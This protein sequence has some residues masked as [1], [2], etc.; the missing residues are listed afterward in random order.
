MQL[1]AA[2]CYRALAARDGRF[3]GRFF[4]GVRTTGI[5]CRPV[6]PARTPLLRNVAFYPSAAAAAEAGFRPCRRCRPETAPGTPAWEGTSAT[7]T[8]ALRLVADGALDER[9]VDTLA[10][11]LGI[12]ERHLRRLFRR[13]LGASPVALAQTRRLHFAKRLIDETDLPMTEVALASGYRSLRRF[14]AAVRDAYEMAPTALRRAARGRRGRRAWSEGSDRGHLSLRLA[15]REPIALPP[16]FD[17]LARRAVPGVEHVTVD[18][19]RRVLEIDDT[20]VCIAVI[21]EGTPGAI[22]LRV[23][24][25]AAAS[26]GRIVAAVRG[27]FDLDADP[28]TIADALGRDALLAPILAREPGLRVPGA[29]DGHEIAVR[30]VLGQ[31]VSVAGART[32]TARL[33]ARFGRRQHDA[34]TDAHDGADPLCRAFPGPAALA[35]A[36]VA[37]IG[38]PARRAE[39]V[40]T[41]SRAVADGA[42]PLSPGTDPET[43]REALLAIPGIGPWTAEYI[44]MRALRE[45]DAFPGGDLV[46]RR[47]AA[48]GAAAIPERA[49]VAR[50]EAW[51]PWRAYAVVAL[52]RAAATA[53]RARCSA[54]HAEVTGARRIGARAGAS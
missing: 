35:E 17:F 3:D 28:Q 7:V 43:T 8:R 39:A 15:Y 10:Q 19:Y 52:W 45:P 25:A 44:A 13:H 54:A 18:T 46:L 4:V 11:R 16:L 42:L 5:Y 47:M 1:D 26:L 37:A 31:Q 36:D 53:P 24:A 20:A 30:A 49:L 2:R 51:R 40:R 33:A 6:C 34:R 21:D 22:T 29:A 38:V 48:A 23:P 41:L 32:L 9:D 12:G 14:N 50:A 27:L